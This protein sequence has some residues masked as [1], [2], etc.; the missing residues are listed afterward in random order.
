MPHGMF[1][2]DMFNNDMFNTA[3]HVTMGGVWDS[4]QEP[5]PTVVKPWKGELLTD[6]NYTE[7]TISARPI[8][9]TGFKLNLRHVPRL[10]QI[11]RREWKT[12]YVKA[13]MITQTKKNLF[14]NTR[15]RKTLQ[16][17]G[18]HARSVIKTNLRN[19]F[20]M[21]DPVKRTEFSK[22]FYGKTMHGLNIINMMMEGRFTK[23]TSK[24][25]SS[26]TIRLKDIITLK[27][28]KP[29]GDVPQTVLIF[30]TKEDARVDCTI[31]KPFNRKRFK[32]FEAN[33]PVLPIHPNCRCQWQDPKTKRMLGQF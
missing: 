10:V 16:P 2:S 18:V 11:V 14:G 12:L 27:R 13:V 23:T 15:M 5:T 32:V 4:M 6:R 22:T 1:N 29:A 25:P 7:L 30:R 3:I 8:L 19:R 24:K 31:C 9:K 33:R 21:Y 28:G 20:L 17:M 26:K